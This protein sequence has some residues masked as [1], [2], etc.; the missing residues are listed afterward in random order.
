MLAQV[1]KLNDYTGEL[2]NMTKEVKA[3]AS[4]TNLLALNAAIEAARAGEAGRGFAVVADAVRKLSQESSATGELMSS[5]VDIINAA[6]AQAV[7]VA[8]SNSERSADMIA[9]SEETIRNVLARF[10]DVTARLSHSAE[11]LQREGSGIREELDDVLVALQ[12]QD[13]TSQILCHVRN[14]LDQLLEHLH[15]RANAPSQAGTLDTLSWLAEME[16]TYATD[17]Q[18]QSHKGG[19]QQSGTEHEITFF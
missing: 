11:L 8:D 7:G 9:Q 1:Q 19:L 15:T 18:R 10:G 13:R 6:I 5:K 2:S 4:Q 16:R 17:E 14:N 12:F 3:I